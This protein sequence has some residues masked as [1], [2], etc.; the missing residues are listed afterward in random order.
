MSTPNDSQSNISPVH[1]STPSQP[2][3]AAQDAAAMPAATVAPAMAAPVDGFK[4][5]FTTKP[6]LITESCDD[7]DRKT[8]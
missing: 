2:A 7:L 5:S 3:A 8:R 6:R 4:P 1:A